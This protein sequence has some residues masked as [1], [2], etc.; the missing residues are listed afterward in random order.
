M[1]EQLYT[2]WIAEIRRQFQTAPPSGWELH[3][4]A[5]RFYDDLKEI[6]GGNYK[7]CNCTNF[8]YSF[9]NSYELTVENKNGNEKWI[10][11][12]KVS[13]IVDAY[14]LHWTYYPRNKQAYV[15]MDQKD[16][17]LQNIEDKIVSFLGSKGFSDVSHKVYNMKLEDVSL[18]LSDP[19]E[20]TV[21]KC[22]FDDFECPITFPHWNRNKI[23]QMINN[24]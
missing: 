16:A 21:G 11:A 8:D 5:D 2:T 1:T 24:Q 12:I 4:D 13:F 14:S 18:E 9:C 3:W 23:F 22:L 10:L 17:Q 20:V 19:D 15:L 6:L 7:L